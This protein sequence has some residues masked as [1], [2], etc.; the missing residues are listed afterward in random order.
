MEQLSVRALCV[1]F[2]QNVEADMGDLTHV[3]SSS[4]AARTLLDRGVEALGEVCAFLEADMPKQGSRVDKAWI[5][6][7][8]WGADK[9]NIQLKPNTNAGLQDWI[10]GAGMLLAARGMEE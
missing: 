3:M 10:Q 1:A 6:L 2:E 4:L 5:K 8:Q 7:F 9:Y